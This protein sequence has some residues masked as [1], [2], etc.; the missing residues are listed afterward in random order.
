MHINKK[1]DKYFVVYRKNVILYINK[2]KLST[3]E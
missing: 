3:S 2:N 1:T